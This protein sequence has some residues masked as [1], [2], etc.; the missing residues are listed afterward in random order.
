MKEQAIRYI[1][2]L[3]AFKLTEEC[4]S[5]LILFRYIRFKVL[6]KDKEVERSTGY[7]SF[8]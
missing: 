7:N 2:V 3:I 1:I 6:G 8:F 5:H 4:E